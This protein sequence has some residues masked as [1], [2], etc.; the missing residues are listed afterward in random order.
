M[1]PIVFRTFDVQ[2]MTTEGMAEERGDN[3]LVLN[4]FDM[5]D[6]N[7]RVMHGWPAEKLSSVYIW[8]F[9]ENGRSGQAIYDPT[10]VYALPAGQHYDQDQEPEYQGGGDDINNWDGN[11]TYMRWYN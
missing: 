4:S 3:L 11:Q 5:D 10:H 1:G 7:V 9:G 6:E 2:P 8:S